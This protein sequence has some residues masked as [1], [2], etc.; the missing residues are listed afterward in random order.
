MFR[1]C[2]FPNRGIAG[3]GRSAAGAGSTL[4]ADSAWQTFARRFGKSFALY[5]LLAT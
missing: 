1:R 3:F 4:S 2:R 5:A